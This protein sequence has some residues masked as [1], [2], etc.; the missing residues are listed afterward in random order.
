MSTKATLAIDEGGDSFHLY[1]ELMDG[2]VWLEVEVDALEARRLPAG[3]RI[4]LS[5]PL[6]EAVLDQLFKPEYGKRPPAKR[7]S[8]AELNRW[9]DELAALS[10]KARARRLCDAP[11]PS[12]MAAR[13]SAPSRAGPGEA[14][15][16]PGSPRGRER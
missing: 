16:R 5:F 12:K 14:R 11:R 10:R 7:R 3:K 8:K 2:R 13:P 15:G 6:P 1:E 4:A 9:L